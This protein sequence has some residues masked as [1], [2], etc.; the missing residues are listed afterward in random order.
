MWNKILRIILK[1]C[2][3]K[4]KLKIKIDILKVKISCRLVLLPQL[5]LF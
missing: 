1:N 2:T 4:L 3:S 5:I